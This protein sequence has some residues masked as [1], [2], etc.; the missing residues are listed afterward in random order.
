MEKSRLGCRPA[1]GRKTVPWENPQPEAWER[2]QTQK[3]GLA[4]KVPSC[5]VFCD[6]QSKQRTVKLASPQVEKSTRWK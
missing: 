5:L 2:L 1:I 6:G 4:P 3:E